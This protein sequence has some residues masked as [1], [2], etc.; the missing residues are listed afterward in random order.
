MPPTTCRWPAIPAPTHLRR[1]SSTRVHVRGRRPAGDCCRALAA[2]CRSG[3]HVTH[4][5]ITWMPPRSGR[6]GRMLARR[7][8][9]DGCVG[10]CLRRHI[11]WAISQ[12]PRVGI[13]TNR[14]AT[15]LGDAGFAQAPRRAQPGLA[16]AVDGA[17]IT[18]LNEEAVV[19]AAL[20]QQGSTSW[21]PTQ[22]FAVKTPCVAPGDPVRPP[23][24]GGGQLAW[25]A[26]GRHCG[27]LAYLGERQERAVTNTHLGR[28]AAG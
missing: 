5:P 15:Q 7:S 3:A 18:A 4:G 13:R 20:G 26:V 8:V 27:H 25:V 24:G 19:S 6:A 14:A 2:L 12:P 17:V 16:E 21:S 9:S 1:S 11:A 22:A 28:S 10:C 23:P